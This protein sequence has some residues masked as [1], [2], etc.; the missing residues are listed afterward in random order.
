MNRRWE[1][2]LRSKNAFSV[3]LL[4]KQCNRST[5]VFQNAC[6]STIF[7]LRVYVFICWKLSQNKFL[8]TNHPN[9]SP[10]VAQRQISGP[11]M[12]K[13]IF[14]C[15]TDWREILVERFVVRWTGQGEAI[16]DLREELSLE[17]EG[18]STDLVVPLYIY[19]AFT[20]GSR[21]QL[22]GWLQGIRVA[23]IFVL[24]VL[25]IPSINVPSA[26]SRSHLDREDSQ[27]VL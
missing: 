18:A 21:T 14:A 27:M 6:D 13:T 24:T 15:G 2:I 20:D 12:A 22:S 3:V 8:V 7:S 10:C 1:R 19:P 9:E 26:L 23:T 16:N 17:T 25:S 4:W 11:S 5:W